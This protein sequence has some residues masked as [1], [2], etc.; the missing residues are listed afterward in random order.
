MRRTDHRAAH[1]RSAVHA[2]DTVLF[3]A[4]ELRAVSGVAESGFSG[5]A[6]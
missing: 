5:E 2:H 6:E 1:P 4:L 3:V